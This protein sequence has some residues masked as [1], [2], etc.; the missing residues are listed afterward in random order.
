MY[1]HR[2]EDKVLIVLFNPDIRLLPVAVNLLFLLSLV[3]REFSQR[4]PTHLRQ[5][6]I[7]RIRFVRMCQ[8]GS[9]GAIRVERMSMSEISGRFRVRI[10]KKI[11]FKG[12]S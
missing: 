10:K 2:Q 9:S 11:G 4:R 6:K 3:T 1:V 8:S 5:T 12:K 7:Y